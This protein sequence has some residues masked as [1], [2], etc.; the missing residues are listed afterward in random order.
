MT[1]VDEALSA[2]RGGAGIID[3]KDPSHG[4]LG[5]LPVET[6]A[7]VRAALPASIPVS[8]TIGD[9]PAI[10]AALT[11]AVSAM[12]A[13]G[14]DIVKIGFF[15]GGDAVAVIKALGGLR[16]PGVRLVGLL[17]A[18]FEPDCSLIPAMARVGFAGVMLDTAGKDGRALTDHLPSA[19]LIG[20]ISA[21]H[22]CGLFAGLAGSLRLSHVAQ[23]VQLRP[24]VLGFRGALCE[25][26]LRTGALSQARVAAVR[27]SIE[28]AAFPGEIASQGDGRRMTYEQR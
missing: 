20:F 11:A 27:T 15:P 28:S 1:S 3:C 4:A 26:G 18:D 24:D 9:L 22:D 6:V 12:A 13:S 5:A 10:P 7:A 23:L 17:L 19:A 16:L 8:A 2:W 21:A 25:G 14:C